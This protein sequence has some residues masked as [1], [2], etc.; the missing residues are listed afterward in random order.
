MC[1]NFYKIRVYTYRATSTCMVSGPTKYLQQQT[2]LPEGEVGVHLADT[3]R[4]RHPVALHVLR[5]QQVVP[6]SVL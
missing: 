1:L 4:V 5:P 3:D 2:H 6:D